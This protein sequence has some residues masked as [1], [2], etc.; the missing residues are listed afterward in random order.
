MIAET[1]AEKI[2]ADLDLNLEKPLVP[3]GYERASSVC[4]MTETYLLK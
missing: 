2:I 4:Y 3:A 1:A